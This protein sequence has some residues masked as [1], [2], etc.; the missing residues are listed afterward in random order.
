[1]REAETAGEAEGKNRPGEVIGA[2]VEVAQVPN[3]ENTDNPE[4]PPA[5]SPASDPIRRVA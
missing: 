1:M 4:I 3:G 2:A 5:K